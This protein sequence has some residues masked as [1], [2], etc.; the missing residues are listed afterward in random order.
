M[1]DEEKLKRQGRWQ[2][3]MKMLEGCSDTTIARVGAIF[4][5]YGITDGELS[6]EDA[7]RAGDMINRLILEDRQSRCKHEAFD[8]KVSINRIEDIKGFMADITIQCAQ[9][10]IPFRFRGMKQGLSYDE[11]MMSIDGTE[12]RLPIG[13]AN[14][15]PNPITGVTGF[16]IKRKEGP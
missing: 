14:Q 8:G 13:P 4:R 15:I 6:D 16:Q 1:A 12:A 9:C 10:K 11:P 2:D 7:T 5:E 3:F